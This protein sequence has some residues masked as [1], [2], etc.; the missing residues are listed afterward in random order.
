M[1]KFKVLVTDYVFENF[2]RESG[3]VGMWRGG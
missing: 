2:D 3:G 1:P